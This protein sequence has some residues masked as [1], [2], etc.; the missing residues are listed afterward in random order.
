MADNTK[1]FG[2]EQVSNLIFTCSSCGSVCSMKQARQGCACS[3][4]VFKVAR[5][6]TIFG[7]M[8]E[9]PDELDPYREQKNNVDNTFGGEGTPTST[10]GGPNDRVPELPSDGREGDL[11]PADPYVVTQVAD[12]S[13]LK[14]PTQQRDVNP[15]NFMHSTRNEDPYELIRKRKFK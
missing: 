4:K 7:P 1:G 6:R 10:V 3:S 2:A 5:K 11:P 15:Y 12:E 14:Q 8:M 13:P 9:N